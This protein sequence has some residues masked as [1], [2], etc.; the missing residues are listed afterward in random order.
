MFV[1]EEKFLESL[2]NENT[3]AIF[4]MIR[5][6]F[7]CLENLSESVRTSSISPEIDLEG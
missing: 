2:T 5:A 1:G 6:P 7:E 3:D 4:F